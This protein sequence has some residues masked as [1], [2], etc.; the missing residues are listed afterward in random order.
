MRA[1]VHMV[2]SSVELR[3]AFFPAHS[4]TFRYAHTHSLFH[5]VRL[6]RAAGLK[7]NNFIGWMNGESAIKWYSFFTPSNNEGSLAEKISII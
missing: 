5:L 3:G 1:Y 2:T 6:A 4:S 7:K